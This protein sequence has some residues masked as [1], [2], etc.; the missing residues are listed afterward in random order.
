M[1]MSDP[2]L[3]ISIIL[4][5]PAHPG[6][7]GS[8]ARAMRNTGFNQL[9]LVKP[10][11]LSKETEW[12]AH[13][14][15]DIVDKAVTLNTFADLQQHFDLLFA[16]SNR[17]RVEKRSDVLPNCVAEMVALA[18]SQRVGIVF[19]REN[20]GLTNDEISHCH[21]L[22]RLP[23]AVSYP[24]YNLAQAVLLS[25]YEIMRYVQTE[26]TL[27]KAQELATNSEIARLEVHFAKTLQ[28]I[29]YYPGKSNAIHQRMRQRFREIVHSAAL[30]AKN[31]RFIHKYFAEII[32]YSQYRRHGD[33]N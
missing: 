32:N 25:A 31:T 12:L 2:R 13:G 10:V 1:A 21:R 22:L 20:N 4:I 6:N 19:G 33:K 16:T 14:A 15:I 28:A 5:E 27:T 11:P 24:A 30:S 26:E 18:G 29:A 9:V 23:S 7:I 8:V 3:N 17:Q